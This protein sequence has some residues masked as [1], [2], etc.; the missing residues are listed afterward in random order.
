MP[1]DE[2]N[3]DGGE[4][5]SPPARWW[6]ELTALRIDRARFCADTALRI[7]ELEGWKK[8]QNGDIRRIRDDLSAF[9][10]STQKWLV[11]L[12]TAVVL[13]L[14]LLVVNLVIGK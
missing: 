9:K 8:D 14:I 11:S 2:R 1:G 6:E 10:E 4:V 12:L 5:G 7:E 13:S 3:R